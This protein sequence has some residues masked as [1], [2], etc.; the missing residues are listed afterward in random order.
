[1][2]QIN[3]YLTFEGNCRDAMDYYKQCLGGELNIQTVGETP[4]GAKASAEEKKAVM[5]AALTKGASSSWPPT[6]WEAARACRGT[7]WR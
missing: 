5:H 2:K 6:G 3:A 4:M 7:A 1:M